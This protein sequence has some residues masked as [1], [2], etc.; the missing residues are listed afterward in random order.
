MNAPLP[1]SATLT[2]GVWTD[3]GDGNAEYPLFMFD[4]EAATQRCEGARVISERGDLARAEA[5]LAA[6]AAQ[7]ILGE[8]ALLDTT[9]VQS[10]IS[11]FG[12]GRIGLWLPARRME[13]RWTLDRESNADF[14]FVM[15]SC[16]VPRWELLRADGSGTGTDAAWFAREMAGMGVATLVLALH[17]AQPEDL[18]IGAGLVEDLGTRLWLA[19]RDESLD[20]AE[21]VRDAGIRQL[22]LNYEGDVQVELARL[23]AA[24]SPAALNTT[25]PG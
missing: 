17:D 6:G 7:V 1:V 8:A 2:L 5:L 25:H 24:D 18:A 14:S 9:L 20:A 19:L 10:A 12:T 21:W 15:P 16:P 13:V 3:A 23:A 11:R 4:D 22:V